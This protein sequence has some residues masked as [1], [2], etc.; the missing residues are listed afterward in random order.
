MTKRSLISIVLI[1][2]GFTSARVASAAP[3]E[4]SASSQARPV[5][6]AADVAGPKASDLAQALDKP[7]EQSW[8]MFE[9]K[10]Q[11]RHAANTCRQLLALDATSEPMD[12][13]EDGSP[14]TALIEN[15]WNVYTGYLLGCRV[16]IA[17]Q[18]AKPSRVDYLGT[19]TLDNASLKAIPAAVIPTPSDEEEQRLKKA[20][21]R[22]VSW[23]R[24]DRRIHVTKTDRGTVIVD[25]PDT[26]CF[27]TVEGR[28]DFDGDGVEDLI[29]YRSGGGQE[30]SWNSAGAFI[31]TRRSPHGRVEVVKVIE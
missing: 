24:W 13:N 5:T 15:D 28:G 3:P 17:I 25:S 16:L 23:K 4:P 6:W 14:P 26:H 1:Y 8:T 31:L 19:F 20:S 7:L 2:E 12:V 27:L 9:R 18:N 10:T 30:G 21:A 29:L 22:G 11:T